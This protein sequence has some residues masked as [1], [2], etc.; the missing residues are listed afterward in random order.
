MY[1][2]SHAARLTGVPAA[3]LRVWERRYGLVSPVRT[4][5]GYRLY[6]E[7]ALQVVR[8]MSSL[9][10]AGWAPRQAADHL[11][12]EDGGG[13]P[14]G[15]VPDRPT[16]D[17]DGDGDGTARVG[18]GDGAARLGSPRAS[19]DDLEALARGA[20]AMD[21]GAVSDAMDEAF[22]RGAFED[23]VDSWLMPSLQVV[24][25][26]WRD[27][28]VDVAGEHVVSAT[29]HRH[30]GAAMEASDGQADG[31]LVAIGLARG[32]HHELGVLAFSVVLRRRGVRVVHLGT[33]LPA[34]HWVDVVRRR[35][36]G[37]VVVG[38]PMRS[39][40]IAVRETADALHAAYPGCPVYVGGGAQDEVGHGTLALGHTLRAAA[41]RLELDLVADGT[42]RT[43]T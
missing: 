7:H 15:D 32:S 17:A 36:P 22:A 9:V 1:T 6:D 30:L 25:T 33:D 20:A 29:V 21:P 24:G 26:W 5:G 31:P 11:L 38:V 43:A 4:D 23:V 3:T 27:G 18:D 10:A 12:S 42:T 34:Q 8:A 19:D 40:V 16:P 14:T 39:D 35:S 28:R 2:I 41:D 13:I 37:A